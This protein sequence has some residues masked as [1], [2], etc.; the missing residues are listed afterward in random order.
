MD[1]LG[2]IETSQSSSTQ[3]LYNMSVEIYKDFSYIEFAQMDVLTVLVA[4]ITP[5]LLTY[6]EDIW[7]RALYI[8]S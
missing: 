4:V 1:S 2:I 3:A 7:E 5:T 6:P 8:V